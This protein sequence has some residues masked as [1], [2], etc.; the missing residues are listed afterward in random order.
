MKKSHA[1]KA[2]AECEGG[3]Y[4]L[5]KNTCS[6]PVSMDHDRMNRVPSSWS[7]AHESLLITRSTQ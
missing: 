2:S 5:L 6:C 4:I 7:H 3:I 1:E